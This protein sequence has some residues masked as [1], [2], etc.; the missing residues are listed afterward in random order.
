MSDEKKP[1][2]IIESTGPES[3]DD[4]EFSGGESDADKH[5]DRKRRREGD[6]QL[7]G[8]NNDDD[9]NDD[10]DD[11][12]SA[13]GSG[14]SSES[15]A[16]DALDTIDSRQI[17]EAPA[18]RRATRSAIRAAAAPIAA[19]KIVKPRKDGASDGEVELSD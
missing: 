17:I 16:S 9:D 1:E 6:D 14:S 10:D 2:T 4:S 13:S 11:G 5:V 8:D 19:P 7:P 18:G 3:E 15:L 12:T